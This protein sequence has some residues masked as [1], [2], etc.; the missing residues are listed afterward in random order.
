MGGGMNRTRF[1]EFG[2]VKVRTYEFERSMLHIARPLTKE[3]MQI[4]FGLDPHDFVSHVNTIM[5]GP[6][7]QVYFDEME[8]MM[9]TQLWQRYL[10]RVKV[11]H[12]TTWWDAFKL[13]WFPKR[14]LARWPAN[15][16]RI[17]IDVAEVLNLK[18]LPAEKSAMGAV[19]RITDY[20][21][22][23]PREADL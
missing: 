16:V 19:Y 22:P 7:R 11:E 5:Q 6:L 23:S 21:L 20:T 1:E 3:E 13:R 18:A 17:D 2:Q 8:L 12:P 10:K 14:W 9:R 15:M 4:R